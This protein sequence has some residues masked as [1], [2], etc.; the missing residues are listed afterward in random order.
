[1]QKSDDFHDD[2]KSVLSEIGMIDNLSC[3][4]AQVEVKHQQLIH[5]IL[6]I[7]DHSFECSRLFSNIGFFI[8]N[9]VP[10]SKISGQKSIR[11][12]PVHSK[13]LNKHHISQTFLNSARPL[14]N[15]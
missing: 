9:E 4:N 6:S 14:Y 11:G 3:L 8:E 12:A 5:Q 7:F 2:N 10:T 15:S 13:I 1:M